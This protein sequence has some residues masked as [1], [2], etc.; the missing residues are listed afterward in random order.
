MAGLARADVGA[1][2]RDDGECGRME[3]SPIRNGALKVEQRATARHFGQHASFRTIGEAKSSARAGEVVVV[4]AALRP[5]AAFGAALYPFANML[6][7]LRLTYGAKPLSRAKA[8]QE[9][10]T[11]WL[12][13]TAMTFEARLF[14]HSGCSKWSAGPAL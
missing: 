6:S 10:H 14:E 11:P 7:A 2:L 9:L 3:Q 1:G 12:T 8:P 4:A 13:I 5:G